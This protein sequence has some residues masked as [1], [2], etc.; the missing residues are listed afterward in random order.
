MQTQI[1]GK[2]KYKDQL[3]III[4]ARNREFFYSVSPITQ[5]MIAI[6]I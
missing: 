3:V 2:F 1:T 6:I 5:Q 4:N